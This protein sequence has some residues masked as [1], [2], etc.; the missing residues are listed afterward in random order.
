MGKVSPENFK[1]D[2]L[3]RDAIALLIKRGE[4]KIRKKTDIKVRLASRP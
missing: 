4:I 3:M 1:F 2:E